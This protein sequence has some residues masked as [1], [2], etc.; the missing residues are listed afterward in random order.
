MASPPTGIRLWAG[1]S[2]PPAEPSGTEFPRCAHC[3]EVIGV[4][5]RAIEVAEHGFARAT[6]RAAEPQLASIA[7][8]AL[9]HAC[10]YDA[11]VAG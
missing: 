5:E 3:G 9:Y 1:M 11:R 6:S 7:G 4:Y 8:T 2:V 10:C